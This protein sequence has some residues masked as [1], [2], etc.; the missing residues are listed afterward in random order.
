M[1]L[2]GGQRSLMQHCS[3]NYSENKNISAKNPLC[4]MNASHESKN[5]LLMSQFMHKGAKNK[6]MLV[7]LNK[8]L[9]NHLGLSKLIEYCLLEYR[10]L[11]LF[12]LPVDVET[13]VKLLLMPLLLK[14]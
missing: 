13:S 11:R 2:R 1:S 9:Q 10:A 14:L 6:N 3:F 4:C 5:S 12:S 8:L 7:R